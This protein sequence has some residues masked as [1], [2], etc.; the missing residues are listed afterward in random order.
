MAKVRR[1][2]KTFKRTN[3]KSKRERER[4]EKLNDL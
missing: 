3:G 2:Y 4:E 1:I